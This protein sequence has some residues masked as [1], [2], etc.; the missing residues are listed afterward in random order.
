MK[1]F[2]NRLSN[3]AVIWTWIFNGF[4]LAFGIIVLPLVLRVLT[5]A[6]LGM[7]YVLLSLVALAPIVD[8]GFGTTIG[9]FVS[10]AMGGAEVL[11]AHGMPDPAGRNTPNYPLLWQLLL[12]TRRLYRYLALA[13]LVILGI[14]GTYMVELRIGETSSPLITR[15]ALAAT[16]VSTVFDIYSGWW[17]AYLRGLNEMRVAARIG[18]MALAVKFIIS[19]ALL[20]SGGGLLSIPIATFAGSVIQR[21]LARAHTL[22]RLQGTPRPRVSA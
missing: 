1:I 17:A 18:V 21:H 10:Y 22:A 19:I 16:L 12:V 7:Y 2:L 5:Q 9:R 14:W 3:S 13:V 4:R 11:Q 15:L 6:D 8:F 20:L